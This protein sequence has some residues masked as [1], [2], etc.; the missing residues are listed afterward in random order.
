[1][2]YVKQVMDMSYSRVAHLSVGFRLRWS[3]TIEFYLRGF[4]SGDGNITKDVTQQYKIGLQS[5]CK[6]GLEGLREAFKLLGFHP[7]EI[8][9][10]KQWNTKWRDRYHFSI[11]AYEHMRFVKEIG[12][13]QP[14]RMKRME[15]I[16]RQPKRRSYK[17]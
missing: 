13:D 12:T 14:N 10:E 1:M 9:Q 17:K 2:K 5:T 6:E 11:S 8:F 3:R 7:L 16:E 15:E 4:F